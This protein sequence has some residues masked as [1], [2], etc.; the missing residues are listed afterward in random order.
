MVI[1]GASPRRTVL[2]VRVAR[3]G[4]QGAE[5]VHGLAV[6]GALG[7]R[8]WPERRARPRAA[9]T[10]EARGGLGGGLVVIVEQERRQRPA[11][12]PFRHGRRACTGST[13]ARTRPA[14]AMMDWPDFEIDRLEGA[15]GALDALRGSYRRARWRSASS[16]SAGTDRC[17]GRRCRRA[18]PRASICRPPRAR[19]SRPSSVMV[20]REVLG[21]LVMLD[22]GADRERDRCPGPGAG[23]L[24]ARSRP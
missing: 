3:S 10:G 13:C 7:L 21:H 22:H 19:S 9:A 20:R 1:E 18:R 17:A 5:A 14:Q 4:E 8:P 16:V 11:H 24:R 12:V 6:V 2:R 23:A 15:E